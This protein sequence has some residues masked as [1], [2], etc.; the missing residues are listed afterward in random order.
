MAPVDL[1]AHVLL[2]TPHAVVGA[3][4]HRNGAG[5]G[6]TLRFFNALPD[7]GR[8]MLVA[9]QISLVVV[10]PGLPEMAGYPCGG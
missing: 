10:C 3:P 1:G 4:Y 9:R 7:E 2:Y 5:I 8:A 6:D